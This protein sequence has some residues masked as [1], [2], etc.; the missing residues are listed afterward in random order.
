MTTAELAVVD[1]ADPDPSD[2]ADLGLDAL[3]A[4]ANR[5]HEACEAA[6]DAALGNAIAA[7]KALIEA[8]AKVETGTWATW[9]AH[10]FMTLAPFDSRKAASGLYM[11]LAHN[12]RALLEAGVTTAKGA[13]RLVQLAD[14][15]GPFR[16]EGAGF[17]VPAERIEHARQLRADGKT[18]REI[19]DDL[20][21][22]IPTA[23]AYC[24]ER[25]RDRQRENQRRYRQRTKEAMR[26]L[27]AKELRR[28]ARK[29]GGPQEEA[30][31]MAERLQDV[32]GQ[33]HAKSTAGRPDWAIAGEHYRKMRDAIVRALGKEM[34]Q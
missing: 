15:P 3:A 29:L 5:E 14:L 11:R 13:A 21:V 6:I 17:A 23:H 32:L 34:G 30:Y 20:G 2:L 1:R 28:A 26:A 10:N 22:S 19:A 31:A 18:L 12:E 25:Q 4:I 27:A 33:A 8:R 9:L 16:R 24:N 7:G